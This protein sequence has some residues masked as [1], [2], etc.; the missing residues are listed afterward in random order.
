MSHALQTARNDIIKVGVMGIVSHYLMGKNLAEESVQL[1]ILYMIMGYVLYD[2]VLAKYVTEER[3]KEHTS[4]VHLVTKMATV[5]TTMRLLTTRSLESLTDGRW[6][7]STG[8]MLLGFGAYELVTKKFVRTE[9][10]KGDWKQITDDWLIWGTMFLVS[11]YLSGGDIT[12]PNFLNKSSKTILGF[13]T[14]SL[15]DY[16]H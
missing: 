2:L 16:V 15:V 8:Y 12:D 11:H 7:T 3:F 5:F 14:G 13:N 9:E 1:E 4:L 6:L 10:R